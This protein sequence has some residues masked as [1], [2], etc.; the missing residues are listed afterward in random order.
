MPKSPGAKV[1][2]SIETGPLFH[3]REVKIDGDVN[4]AARAAFGLQSGAPAVASQVLAAGQ[5]LLDTLQE[6]GHAFAKVDD[7]IAY[8]DASE[9][10]LDVSFKVDAGPVYV[11]GAIRFE[12]LKHLKESFLRRRLLLH[13]GQPYSPSQVEKARTDLLALG[14]FSSIT[15]QLPKQE[16]VKDG[17]LPLVVQIQERRRHT[18][19]LNA[20]YSSDLGGSGGAT[21]GDRDLLGNAE[22]LNLSAS[23][24]NWGG[25]DTTTTG[26]D[27]GAQLIKPDFRQRDQSL[28]FGIV[29][30]KQDL[31]AYDQTA[32][33]ASA[34]LTRKLSST[35]SASMAIS[36]EEERILQECE[37]R[38]YT[39]FSIPLSAKYDSTA[40]ASPLDDPLM[41]RA[42]PCRWP[43]RSRSVTVRRPRSPHRAHC[44]RPRARR[45]AAARV[46]PAARLR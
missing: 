16:D 13:P 42:L 20:A 37:S 25:S 17:Q 9:P 44:V 2:V 18:V 41:A 19:T 36:V 38:Y 30:L 4:E 14:V 3:L 43:P 24:I 21:W 29:A 11:L 7:P 6:Q 32:T 34:T 12:G 28:Q 31:Q 27:L 45:R 5:R 1:Q 8:E 35:W 40:L 46:P 26:Y 39:L 23:L 15:V 10:L 22:Q 33:T